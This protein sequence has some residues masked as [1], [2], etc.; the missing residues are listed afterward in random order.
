MNKDSGSPLWLILRLPEARH[1]HHLFSSIFKTLALKNIIR[2]W[3][4]SHD[5]RVHMTPR[6][7]IPET[8]TPRTADEH[9]TIHQQQRQPLLFIYSGQND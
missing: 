1:Q 6:K 7:V 8:T 2:H 9:T 5:T 4:F 3:S